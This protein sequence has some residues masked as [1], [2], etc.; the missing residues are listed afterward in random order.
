MFKKILAILLCL[1][2]LVLNG[3]S[4]DIKNDSDKNNTTGNNTAQ[5]TTDENSTKPVA[6][7]VA[8]S[9]D[10]SREKVI[11][12]P[13][14]IV[15]HQQP[16]DPLNLQ[17]KYKNLGAN[18]L[19]DDDKMVCL[20]FDEGYENGYTPSIL[21]TLKEKNVKAVFF[22]TYD[23][24]KD[25][26]QLIERMIDEGHIVGNHTY[27]HYTMD[28]QTND[29]QKEEVEYLHEYIQK[30]FNY[31][32]SYFRFP[33]GEFSEQ[34]LSL[35]NDLGY[36]SVFWSYAYADWDVNSQ[37]D[38][39]ETLKSVLE[40]THSGEIMLLH[41]VSK[42]NSEILGDIIDGV[43]QQGYEFTVAL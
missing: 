13:G 22:V 15:E 35:V 40:S 5:S 41:A 28:E 17:K 24:A 21:D 8:G 30:E 39:D 38:N 18:W 36:K 19:L 4:A 43:R 25:N 9:M 37:P 31:T 23:F 2:A 14:N 27:R 12:G 32:M 29:I 20:T 34:S 16:T 1:C 7:P 11:W 3:C 6:D 10:L 42:T 26:P 33:K